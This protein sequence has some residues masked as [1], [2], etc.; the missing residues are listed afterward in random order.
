MGLCV[1]AYHL[2]R[3]VSRPWPQLTVLASGR[4]EKGHHH[5]LA[6]S[7]ERASGQLAH[8]THLSGFHLPSLGLSLRAG[9]PCGMV[10]YSNWR[11]DKMRH[12]SNKKPL[13]VVE[14]WFFNGCLGYIHDLPTRPVS[15]TKP[16]PGTTYLRSNFQN[17][18]LIGVAP[19]SIR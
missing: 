12:S 8:F 10:P 19:E 7:E 14:E 6:P 17:L 9:H 11:P 1:T 4:N 16:S 5:E 18:E 13:W 3:V 15:Q 2:C